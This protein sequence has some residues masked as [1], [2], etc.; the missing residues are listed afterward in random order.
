MSYV[1]EERDRAGGGVRAL[2]DSIAIPL[3]TRA[4]ITGGD[5]KIG[6]HFSLMRDRRI[7]G[8]ETGQHADSN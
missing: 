1:S 5:Y 3:T 4:S 6:G 2:A 7:G 8:I